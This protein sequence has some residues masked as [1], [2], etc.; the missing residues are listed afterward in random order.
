MNRENREAELQRWRFVR[1][2]NVLLITRNLKAA[3]GR[4]DLCHIRYF[5]Q[6]L[7]L[8]ERKLDCLKQLTWETFDPCVLER[9]EMRYFV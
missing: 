2:T 3:R 4:G 9:P 5:S 1:E 7:A 6:Q 8:E